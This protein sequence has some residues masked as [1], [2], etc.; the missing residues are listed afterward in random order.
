MNRDTNHSSPLVKKPIHVEKKWTNSSAWTISYLEIKKTWPKYLEKPWTDF[1][2]E[3]IFGMN[4]FLVWTKNP[5]LNKKSTM[6][7]LLAK[8]ELATPDKKIKSKTWTDYSKTLTYYCHE[9]IFGM[10]GLFVWN[11]KILPWKK[12][13]PSKQIVGIN[14][15]TCLEQKNQ[16]WTDA[17]NEL[18]I[19]TNVFAYPKTLKKSK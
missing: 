2:H 4:R 8:T 12:I 5:T 15:K 6:N 9:R 14:R 1:W 10:N 3:L 7:G 11:K 17:W 16:P 18:I 19:G 13:E